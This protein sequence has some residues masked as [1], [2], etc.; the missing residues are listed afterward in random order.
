MFGGSTQ[1]PLGNASSLSCFHLS[2][3]EFFEEGER[4]SNIVRAVAVLFFLHK[5]QFLVA[6]TFT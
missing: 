4:N 2:L 1:L 5:S 3:E 6:G